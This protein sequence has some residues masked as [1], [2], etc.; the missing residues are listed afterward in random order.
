MTTTSRPDYAGAIIWLQQYRELW[1][2]A[3]GG[4]D[5]GRAYEMAGHTSD[6][7]PS[8]LAIGGRALQTARAAAG[9]TCAADWLRDPDIEKHVQ[10]IDAAIASVRSMSDGCP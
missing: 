10:V 4:W 5:R 1:R 3:A 7:S 9:Y 6:R 8:A 2:T